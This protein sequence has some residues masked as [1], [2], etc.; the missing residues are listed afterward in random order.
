MEETLRLRW[1]KVMKMLKERFGKEPDIETIL[2]LIGIQELGQVKRKF[3][4]EQKQD[5]MHIAI[6][7]LLSKDGYYQ[8]ENYDKD[9]W[10]HFRE[11]KKRPPMEPKEQEDFLKEHII[12]YFEQNILNL[13]P[14]PSDQ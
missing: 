1:Q 3:T 5:L 14:S 9:G 10:P 4:K 7:T 2:F 12:H 13:D 8:F 6:C 11:I